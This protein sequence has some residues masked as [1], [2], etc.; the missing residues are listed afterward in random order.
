MDVQDSSI[1][2]APMTQLRPQVQAWLESFLAGHGGVAGTVHE[3]IQE[4]GALALVAAVNI[5][6]KVLEVTAVVPRGKG[7]AGLALERR[8]AV[9]TCNLAED[10]SGDVQPGAKAVAAQAAAAL[11]VLENGET[12]GVVGIAFADARDLPEDVLEALQNAARDVP[13]AEF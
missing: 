6:P 13:L 5:P 4:G 7:M 10:K 12:F 11:P 2:A 3:V 9:S 8:R 1:G